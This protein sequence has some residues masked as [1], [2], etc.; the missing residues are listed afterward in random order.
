M[1]EADKEARRR[2][3]TRAAARGRGRGMPGGE[4][5]KGKDK[6]EEPRRDGVEFKRSGDRAGGGGG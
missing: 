6:R 3:Q 2:W 4:C 5:E 1:G